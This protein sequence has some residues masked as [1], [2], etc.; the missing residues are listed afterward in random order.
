MQRLVNAQYSNSMTLLQEYDDAPSRSLSSLL[1]FLLLLLLLWH[2]CHDR[3]FLCLLFFFSHVPS[4]PS[5]DSGRA[6]WARPCDVI[7]RRMQ[8]LRIPSS[9]KTFLQLIKH[10]Y[11]Y[12][13]ISISSW[14]PQKI[15]FL[16]CD[17]VARRNK[18]L[19]RSRIHELESCWAVGSC[20]ASDP[21]ARPWRKQT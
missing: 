11:S 12:R 8:F 16:A 13:K 18:L 15:L 3:C 21:T 20:P 9:Y 10:Y 4:G 5:G 1:S 19:L 17:A 7:A 2:Y 14:N 6:F